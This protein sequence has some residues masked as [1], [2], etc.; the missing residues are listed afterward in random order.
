[1]QCSRWLMT[2]SLSLRSQL[3]PSHTELLLGQTP[4][5]A[6]PVSTSSDSPQYPMPGCRHSPKLPDTLTTA[7]R[8][9]KWCT[10]S[11]KRISFFFFFPV[12]EEAVRGWA[13]DIAELCDLSLT[14]AI[15]TP[16]ACVGV[17]DECLC[18]VIMCVWTAGFCLCL[19]LKSHAFREVKIALVAGLNDFLPFHLHFDFYHQA[20]HL[21]LHSVRRTGE[22]LDTVR[23]WVRQ[24]D[25][26]EIGTEVCRAW[27]CNVA[28]WLYSIR[29]AET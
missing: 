28:G 14:T 17:W 29:L 21:L 18:T 7:Q 23:E 24:T 2:S 16:L 6:T 5:T 19:R 25:G 12:E 20:F 9:A 26:E 15:T 8:R 4:F 1:M 27:F 3:I 11:V 22:L 13:Q 10:Q